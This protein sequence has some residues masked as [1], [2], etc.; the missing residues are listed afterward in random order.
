MFHLE[1]NR[2]KGR[3]GNGKDRSSSKVPELTVVICVTGWG[4]AVAFDTEQGHFAVSQ[5]AVSIKAEGH[6]TLLIWKEG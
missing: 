4:G 5:R 1:G 6:A 3:K 2:G